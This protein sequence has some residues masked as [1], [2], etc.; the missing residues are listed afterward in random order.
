MEMIIKS[1]QEF[2]FEKGN[3][4]DCKVRHVAWN[5][6]L[7][8]LQVFIFD[9][10]AN[11]LGLPEYPGPQPGCL[12]F[13]GVQSIQF[14]ARLLDGKLRIYEVLSRIEDGMSIVEFQFSPNGVLKVRFESISFESSSS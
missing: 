2:F 6:E 5:L 12:I 3:L 1:A 9:L 13:S 10:N 11:F 7:S 14:D 4:H 8:R